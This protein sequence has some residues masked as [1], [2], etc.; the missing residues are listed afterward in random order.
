MNFTV[1]LSPAATYHDVDGSQWPGIIVKEDYKEFLQEKPDKRLKTQLPTIRE[2]VV[3]MW[4]FTMDG[5]VLKHE[6]RPADWEYGC[7][8]RAAW[9][10]YTINTQEVDL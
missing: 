5:V 9:P 4:V 7:V 3:S 8:K 10:V 2:K 1:D 6:V